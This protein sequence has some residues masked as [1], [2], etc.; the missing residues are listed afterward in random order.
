MV[1]YKAITDG[2][3]SKSP[4]LLLKKSKANYFD[5]KVKESIT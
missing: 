2:Q 3:K 1:T 4:L 5:E